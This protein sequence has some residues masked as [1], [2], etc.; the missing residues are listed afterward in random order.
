[1][2]SYPVDVVCDLSIITSS[3]ANDITNAAYPQRHKQHCVRF[4]Q[5]PATKSSPST[6]NFLDV[7]RNGKTAALFLCLFFCWL[8]NSMVFYGI[9]LNAGDF[10]GNMY[11]NA[12]LG[13]NPHRT[14][15]MTMIPG[16]CRALSLKGHIP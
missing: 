7:F 10:G 4:F 5:P 1:M 9:V 6:E 14:G 3:K 13:G 8:V 15:F 2:F 16:I 12:T 11:L